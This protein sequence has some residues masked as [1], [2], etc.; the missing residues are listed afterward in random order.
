MIKETKTLSL[1]GTA[2]FCFFTVQDINAQLWTAGHG[3]IGIGFEGGNLEPH[4]HLGEDNESV[5]LDGTPTTFGSEGMEFEASEITAQTG[6]SLPRPSGTEWDF[7]GNL[8]N[9]ATYL[10]PITEQA[11]VPFLGFGTE[12]LN[13]ADWN[14]PLSLT[15]TGFSGPGN[16]SLYADSSN[17]F[18][19]TSDGVTGADVLNLNA[20]THSHFELAFTD[21]GSYQLTFQAT[22]TAS[23]TP[24]AQ[25]LLDGIVANQSYTSSAETF[26]INVVPEPTTVS[27]LLASLA[28]LVLMRRRRATH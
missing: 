6:F 19:A 7:I 18:M 9:D 20:G 27:L 26:T 13:P 1:I 17:V 25:G 24:S 2:V 4:W 3:D 10:I 12:E 21:V 11:G 23:A 28:G 14:G 8:A 15:L 16:F 5:T 22:G